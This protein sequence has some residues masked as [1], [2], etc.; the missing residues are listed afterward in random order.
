MND[1]KEEYSL[2]D[3]FSLLVKM[4]AIVAVTVAVSMGCANRGA[5]PQGGPVD[6]IPPQL[7]KS[8]PYNGQLNYTKNTMNLDFDEIVLVEG[9]YDKVIVSPPQKTAVVVKALG[10]RVLVEFADSMQPNTS[11]TVDFTDAIVDNNEKNPLRNFSMSFATGDHI[12]S[13][14]M[15]GLLLDASNL[16][17]LPGIVIGIHSDLSDTAFTTTPFKRVT[18]TDLNG[19]FRIRNIA[20]G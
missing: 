3:T 16:N 6:S 4:M 13:L 11:Y 2:R 12:D 7:I 20:P 1:R 18:K 17:P 10:K 19:N 15:A 9:A 5:G 14:Q 8:E